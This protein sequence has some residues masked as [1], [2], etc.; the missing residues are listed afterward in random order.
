MQTERKVVCTVTKEE[1]DEIVGNSVCKTA[2]QK[3]VKEVIQ[4]WEKAELLGSEWWRAVRLK[5]KLPSEDNTIY[6][7]NNVTGEVTVTDDTSVG[8]WLRKT[9]DRLGFRERMRK[10]FGL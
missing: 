10:L 9:E 1:L 3:V 2:C 5:Y 7:I 8:S 4:E 6:T